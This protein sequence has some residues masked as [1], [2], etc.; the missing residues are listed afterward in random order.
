MSEK[1]R[2]KNCVKKTTRKRSTASL[3]KK[4]NTEQ[5]FKNTLHMIFLI[6]YNGEYKPRFNGVYT[7]LANVSI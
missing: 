5:Y 4:N 1:C 2:N 3:N 6:K 7:L